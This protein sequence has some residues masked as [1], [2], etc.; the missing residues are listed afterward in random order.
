MSNLLVNFRFL[1]QNRV[2]IT[3]I[4]LKNKEIYLK[5]LEILV[6]KKYNITNLKYRMENNIKKVN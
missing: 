3:V 1:T 6:R 4:L 5:H 2:E